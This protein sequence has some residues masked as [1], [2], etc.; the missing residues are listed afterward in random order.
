MK[1]FKEYLAESTK[2]YS[3]RVKIAGEVPEGFDKRFQ[4]YMTKYETLEFKKVGT[5]PVQ[6]HPHEFPRIKNQEVTIYDV[7]ASYP[8]SF[9][10]LE[11][12]LADEFGISFNNVK[13]KHP[14]DPTEEAKDDEAVYE[15]KLQDDEYKDDPAGEKPIYGDEY[16]MSMFKELMK[17]RKED[18][19]EAQ[20]GK[21]VEPGQEDTTEPMFQRRD[22]NPEGVQAGSIT[23]HSK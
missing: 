18:K 21:V 9:Q 1:T 10:Q 4:D 14:T 6:E 15:P 5:T 8:I 20:E 3:V 2:T 17:T 7:E 19:E 16:N 22:K 11:H 23:R 13:V 12:T